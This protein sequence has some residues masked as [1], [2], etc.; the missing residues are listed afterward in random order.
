[1]ATDQEILDAAAQNARYILKLEEENVRLGLLVKKAH[2]EGYINGDDDCKALRPEIPLTSETWR[3][4]WDKSQ[5]KRL[6]KP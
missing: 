3:K 2:V 4:H 5:S 1:M 6:L